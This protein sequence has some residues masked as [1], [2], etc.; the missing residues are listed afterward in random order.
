MQVVKTALSP[1]VRSSR[2]ITKRKKSS[3]MWY[4]AVED[5]NYDA[6]ATPGVVPKGKIWGGP[7]GTSP[8]AQ[9]LAD[10]IDPDAS[11]DTIVHITTQIIR[12][13]PAQAITPL[14]SCLMCTY[15]RIPSATS[16]NGAID[17]KILHSMS[18]AA[19]SAKRAVCGVVFKKGHLVWLVKRQSSILHLFIGTKVITKY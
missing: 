16:K 7:R 4:L 12:N 5:A 6:S 18:H 8:S 15:C 11:E 2:K 9:Q 13:A 19:K 1:P 10:L 14:L 3:A 17:T